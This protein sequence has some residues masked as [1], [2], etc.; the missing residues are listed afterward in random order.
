MAA[1]NGDDIV[2][3]II[4]PTTANNG[5]AATGVPNDLTTANGDDAA[6]GDAE[7]RDNMARRKKMKCLNSI[8]FC[9]AFLEWAGNAVGTV[10]FLWATVVLLGGFSTLL[11]RLDFW[12]ATVMILLEGSRCVDLSVFVLCTFRIMSAWPP[13]L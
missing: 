9:I 5:G 1:T 6:G 11:S 12:I 3:P 4:D 10:A 2:V 13:N 7:Q 8:V